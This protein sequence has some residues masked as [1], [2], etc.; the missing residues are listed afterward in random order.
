MLNLDFP[1]DFLFLH[2]GGGFA[3]VL[4]LVLILGLAARATIEIHKRSVEGFHVGPFNNNT[5]ARHS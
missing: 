2:A 3:V 1:Q 4:L 5:I